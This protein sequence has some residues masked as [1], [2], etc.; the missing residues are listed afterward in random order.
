MHFKCIPSFLCL[1]FKVYPV[2]EN[3]VESKL[4]FRFAVWDFVSS[5]PVDGGLQVPGFIPPDVVN[6]CITSARRENPE[7]GR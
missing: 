7:N 3:S 4:V 6:V 5:E 2:F 1:F